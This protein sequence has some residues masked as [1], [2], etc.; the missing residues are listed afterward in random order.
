MY[1]VM[2]ETH[3]GTIGCLRRG[4]KTED[5]ALDHRVRLSFFRPVWVEVQPP[6]PGKDARP[7]GLPW[8]IE[9]RHGAP[10]YVVDVHGRRIATILGPKERREQI[11]AVLER[12]NGLSL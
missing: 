10:S 5:A 7:P 2:G 8:A 4:F 11:A 1:R 12:L 3:D 6:A 9:H